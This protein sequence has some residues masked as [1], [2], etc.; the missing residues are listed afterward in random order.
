MDATDLA[1]AGAARQAELLRSG[2]VSARELVT[3][4]LERIER[5]DPVLNAFRVVFAEQALAEAAVADARLREGQTRP[6]LG[7]AVAIKDDV[8]V[9]GEIT[10][11]G[12]AANGAVHKQDAAVVRAL[13]EAG[14]I[15]IGKTN[16]PEMTIW[17][18]TETLTY[19]VTRN[20]W[21]PGRTPGGSSGGTGAALAAGLV[22][23]GLGS[24]GAGS[25]RIPSTWCGLFGIKPQRDR[26]PL[27]PHDDAW[28]G[29]SVNG[30]LARTVADAALFLDATS[31]TPG[32]A[33]GFTAAAA[34]PPE[35]LRIAVSTAVPP[36]AL[37]KL[38]DA[39][40]RGLEETADL[41]R[42]LGHTVIERDPDYGPSIF[43]EIL[44][45][46]LHGIH[47]DVATMEHP[48]RLERRTRAMARMGAAWTPVIKRLRA[49][50]QATAARVNALFDEVDV[51]LTPATA[52][53]PFRV[54]QFHGR[55]ALWTLNAVA[56]RVPWLG[57]ANATGQ[58]AAAVPVGLDDDGLPM[59]VQ[60]LGRPHDE[61]TLL[62]LAAQL[63][64]AR[65]WNLR[66]PALTS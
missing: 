12:T 38:G 35:R 50:E 49:R 54:G 33:G 66:R 65:P 42:G 30:P 44:G 8:H 13:R 58:P 2:E 32:P 7:V 21:D 60:L 34:T 57:V 55:G 37:A 36:G 46:Y 31:V 16:V 41:L 15:V 25:I 39:E 22:G 56:P 6:L 53:G 17:P 28:N 45:R 26:V 4:H 43:G 23:V 18:F 51:V 27:S 40:R 20:P 48:E 29:M 1:F 3:T 14:A 59:G 62:A 11:W 19:G 5:Y 61:A 10:A 64:V 63:E 47:T 52:R 9:A 24:D